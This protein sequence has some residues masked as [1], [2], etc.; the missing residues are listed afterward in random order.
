MKA[1]S[2]DKLKV[3]HRPPHTRTRAIDNHATFEVKSPAMNNEA[4]NVR[5]NYDN[6]KVLARLN[7]LRELLC[8]LQSPTK[9]VLI[10]QMENDLGYSVN[11]RMFFRDVKALR[12][13][14]RDDIPAAKDGVYSIKFRA[15]LHG[16]LPPSDNPFAAGSPLP[17]CLKWINL[18][19]QQYRR[20]DRR[21]TTNRGASAQKGAEILE[22]LVSRCVQVL[23]R[24]DSRRKLEEQVQL[25]KQGS[26]EFTRVI[27]KMRP[28]LLR[29][30]TLL[31]T[32]DIA[33]L[34]RLLKLRNDILKPSLTMS[35]QRRKQANLVDGLLRG[36]DLLCESD[37]VQSIVAME[38]NRLKLDHVKPLIAVD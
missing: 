37:F 31:S 36:L 13:D 28:D 9:T 34:E 38:R 29:G 14:F 15:A 33:L 19:V 35:L 27:R 22:Q 10:E 25:L 18:Q 17:K 5:H 3:T 11:E 6:R 20:I 4:G 32:K 21:F 8:K 23:S 1:A 7:L 30:D 16:I 12:E 2:S 24:D 26:G